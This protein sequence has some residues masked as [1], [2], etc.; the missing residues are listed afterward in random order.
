MNKDEIDV[1]NLLNMLEKEG[2]IFIPGNIDNK[3]PIKKT[4]S[5]V[6]RL[7]DITTDINSL[8]RDVKIQQSIYF[9]LIN[10]I[11]SLHQEHRLKKNFEVSDIM[12]KLVND[13]GVI[14]VQGTLG[15]NYEE[16]VKK[17]MQNVLSQDTWHF[18]DTKLNKL[19]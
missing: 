18:D 13:I 14:I 3:Q 7:S 17:N 12:R 19:K 8:Q 11:V 10:I 4:V 2:V 15:M 5:L 16:I 6:Q 9:H 1:L